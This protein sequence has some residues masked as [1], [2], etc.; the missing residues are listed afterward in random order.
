[1]TRSARITSVDELL[2]TDVHKYNDMSG[3]NALFLSF[4]LCEMHGLGV[5]AM[6]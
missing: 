4:R 3:F 1:M 5:G 6:R 2:K